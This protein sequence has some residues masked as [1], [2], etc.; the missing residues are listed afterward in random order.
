MFEFSRRLSGV[1]G[2][3]H[4]DTFSTMMHTKRGSS[5]WLST[6]R[7]SWFFNSSQILARRLLPSIG[8]LVFRVRFESRNDTRFAFETAAPE[9]FRGQFAAGTAPVKS[10]VW[11][12]AGFF[13]GGAL[14]FEERKRHPGF[15]TPVAVRR[16]TA[17]KSSSA[18]FKSNRTKS[19]FQ[20]NKNC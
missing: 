16:T 15:H 11:D 20:G 9:H 18:R 17:S 12:E 1:P 5:D 14:W 19:R 4:L 6:L 10:F 3:S 2:F 7:Y 13:K 8:G